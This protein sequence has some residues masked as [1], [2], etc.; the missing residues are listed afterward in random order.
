MME[1]LFRFCK[2]YIKIEISQGNIERFLNMV[3]YKKINIWN[4]TKD[5][6]CAFFYI[7]IK[8]IYKLKPIIRKTKV[9][10]KVKE[11]YGLPFFLFSNRKRK[12]FFIGIFIGWLIVY[13]M[14]LYVWNIS[15]EGNSK[16][17]DEEL[18]KFLKDIHIDEGIKIRD[19]DGELIE[20][21]LRNEFFDITWASVDITGTKLT[22]CVRENINKIENLEEA[23]KGNLIAAKSAEVVSIISSI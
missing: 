3:M 4:I 7:R 14:S 6:N 19:V 22:I 23:L 2:G 21:E 10:F 15:F 18:A 8:D 9:S 5:D 17:T 1:K 16:H 12:I 11:R 13:V 20:K